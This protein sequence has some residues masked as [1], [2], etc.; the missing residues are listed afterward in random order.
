MG[1]AKRLAVL[2]AVLYIAAWAFAGEVKVL[3]DFEDGR[4]K[5]RGSFRGSIVAQ[6]ATH[7]EKAFKVVFESG[8]KY[9]G[10][11]AAKIDSNWR[12]YDALRM[13]VFNPQGA[14]IGVTVR[15]D[16]DR[17][18]GYFSRYNGEF[19]LVNGQTF[20]EIPLGRLRA[21]DRALDLSKIRLFMI[22]MSS[23]D[24][25]V[26]L[27]FDNLRLT[28]GSEPPEAAGREIL[29][30]PESGEVKALGEEAIAE[31]RR[32]EALIDVA[33]ERGFGT[34]EANIAL[35]TA[36]LGLDARPKLKWFAGREAELY[37]YVR[38][39]CETAYDVLKARMEGRKPTCH[40]PPI[41]NTAAL[42]FAG[43]HFAEKETHG[44]SA[45]KAPVL[46]FSMLYHKKGP[47]CEYF[48]PIDYF[49][50][51]HSFA[52]ASR[53]DAE[54]TPLYKAFHKYADTHRVWND[55]EGWC[56]HIVRDVSS[57]GGGKEP[58]VVCLESPHTKDAIRKY[59]LDNAAAW[60]DNPHVHAN[61]LGGE[62]SYIC[63]CRRTL[64]MFRAW[65]KEKHGRIE[66]LNDIW[67]TGF[68]SF[69]DIVVMPNAKQAA[70]NRARW[71]DWQA[72]NCRRF[73]D[74]AAWA[75]SVIREVDT[76]V[77]VSVGAVAYS[78]KSGFGRS[79]V[80]EENLIRRVDDVILNEGGRSTITTDLLWSLAD[81]KKPMLDFE[82][83]GDV[84]GI[85]PHFIHGN[86]AMAMWYWPDKPSTD[87]PHFNRTALPFSWEIPLSDV[88]ECL[89]IALD[90][91][92]LGSRIA[93]F[94]AVRS[95]M[96][97]LYSRASMLQAEPE[98][99]QVTDTP[100]T[101][102]T[103][104]VYDAMLGLD[105][106]VRF[107]SSL[108]VRE[109]NLGRYRLIVVPAAKYV[110]DDVAEAVFK[111]VR[112]GGTVI[113]TP[114]SFLFDE[115]A[116]KRPH[117]ERMGITITG[118]EMPEFALGERRRHEYLQEFIRR[119][120]ARDLPRRRIE[121]VA[122]DVLP[123]GTV[124]Q[125]AGVFQRVESSDKA[126]VIARTAEG[127]PAVLEVPLGKGR[128]YYLAIG[129]VGESFNA[130]A[131]AAAETAGVGRPVRFALA[132]GGRDW[133]IEGRAVETAG[134]TLLYI[135][136]HANEPL[137]VRVRLPYEAAAV[138]DL[139]DTW[140]EVDLSSIPVAPGRTRILAATKEPL[141]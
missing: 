85:L 76:R 130:F 29:S 66:H 13:D 33:N 92:R 80:D 71:F 114:E 57:L 18:T 100:Y 58:L 87:F 4:I 126:V 69:G 75:K 30:G 28:K 136:N 42:E 40:V 68:K 97:I 134:G 52:G 6:Y 21:G 49:A 32:L 43:A 41:Y 83:H 113:M 104:R 55:D 7:G 138:I 26:T 74:H 10:I 16:D 125:G 56:G 54:R 141:S 121:V 90:V 53:Y 11:E 39:S 67:G 9:P 35:I 135:V 139:R 110:F 77:G 112:D 23:P 102:E 73:V 108:Q 93:A 48:T 82:Y 88:A 37:D 132:G 84:G 99:L 91:R 111:F 64:D 60:K 62:L 107:V 137:D 17:S 105:A 124:L 14:P 12:G 61:I 117:L 44:P 106:P 96:A 22:F 70:D 103:K 63:Y 86:T 109:G 94:P 50:H 46:L 101:M 118:R 65:L 15:I 115:Y 128:I 140:R 38:R 89:K 81:G 127:E 98:F 8:V 24:R 47:L 45:H 131:N 59:I 51:T 3:D 36:D 116:R 20:V 122:G 27:Y 78:F 133:R 34:L 129:L 1:H 72:F 120:S 5:W 25:D 31:R 2:P 79:G 119:A 19:L 95:Q 123:G